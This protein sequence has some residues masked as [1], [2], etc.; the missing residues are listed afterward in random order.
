MPEDHAS[1][2]WLRLHYRDEPPDI[3]HLILDQFE[4]VFTL[5]GQQPGA[6]DRVRDA[7]GILLHGGIPEP[8]TR[9]IE[10]HDTFLDAFDPDSVPVRI[11]L[12]MRDDYVYALNRWRRHLPALGQNSFELH[13][14]KGPSAYEAVYEPGALRCQYRGQLHEAVRAET[15]LPIVDR[16]T[17]ER[18]VRFIAQKPEDVAIDNIEAVPPVLSLLCRELNARRFVPPAGTADAP[19][20]R[21]EFREGDAEIGTIIAAF[22]ER[23]LAGRPEAVRIFMEE[24]LVSYSGARLPQD[25]E[26]ILRVFETGCEIPGAPTD[27]RAGGYGYRQAA[28]ACLHELVNQRLLSA[29]GDKRY[30]LIHDLLAQVVAHS[31]AARTERLEKEDAS[32][33][34]EQERQAKVT[35]ERHA[36]LARRQLFAV[37]AAL[38]VAVVAAVVALTQYGRATRARDDAERATRQAQALLGAASLREAQYMRAPCG[39]RRRWRSL[40]A[41]SGFKRVQTLEP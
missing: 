41:R 37:A 8:I 2:L 9:L 29:L 1:R 15:G 32:R 26:S 27:R 4:E 31:R 34:A 21:L 5:G 14:L 20:A 18:I 6:E 40:R 10:E 36:H 39:T 17:A 13:P 24:E 11:I 28:R 35:A 30:E 12:A 33:R 22:Y 3:T 19:A 38:A 25:E 23:C 7:M 16:D